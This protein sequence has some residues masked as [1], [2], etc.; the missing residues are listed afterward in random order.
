MSDHVNIR[1][2]GQHLGTVEINGVQVPRVRSVT[3][4]SEVGEPNTVTLGL[5]G[6][7]GDVTC[8]ADVSRQYRYVGEAQQQ[9][10]LQKSYK[11]AP[12]YFE[13]AAAR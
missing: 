12:S 4:H 1:M 5:I 6:L 10:T 2:T 8:M 9:Y 3:F 11:S 13:W 7:V